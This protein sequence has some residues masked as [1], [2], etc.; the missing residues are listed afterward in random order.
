MG[1]PWL[2]RRRPPS[3]P[4]RSP[5]SPRTL[6]LRRRPSRS[7]RDPS[8]SPIPSGR[9]RAGS[10]F[11]PGRRRWA[12]PRACGGDLAAAAAVVGGRDELLSPKLRNYGASL[13]GKAPAADES[14]RKAEWAARKLFYQAELEFRT[15]ETRAAALDK[16]DGLLGS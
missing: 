9:R 4:S 1:W 14:A 3:R 16:Y 10:I 8:W 11:P 5:R 13:E 12:T 6:P 7:T 2:R 15:L